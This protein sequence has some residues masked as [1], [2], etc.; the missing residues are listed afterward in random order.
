MTTTSATARSLLIVSLAFGLLVCCPVRSAD[1]G[2]LAHYAFDGDA[3]DSSVNGNNASASG[4]VD[5]TASGGG[6]TGN[7]GDRAVNFDAA[8]E[9]VVA[10]V[11]A[12]QTMN[13]NNAATVSLWVFGD[14]AQQPRNDTIFSFNQNGNRQFMS[15]LPWGDGTVYFDTGGCCGSNTR[16]TV[17][18]PAG[19]WKGA[20]NHYTYIKD[21]NNKSL[22]INGTIR[23]NQVGGATAPINA[24]NEAAIGAERTNGTNNYR[25]LV[26]DLGIWDVGLSPAEARALY[27]LAVEP[28]LQ[29]GVSDANR[30]FELFAAGTGDEA[31][32][33]LT[34]INASGLDGSAGDVLYLGG[35]AYQLVLDDNGNGLVGTVPEPAT[36]ALLGLA[37]TG[38][39][40][41]LRRRRT[42]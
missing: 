40:G 18:R 2:L 15:H 1:A 37:A 39:G 33:D 26:D 22:W 12:F 29:Y 21:G 7:V 27:T 23:I 24:F 41:Y 35:G 38:L 10:P 31:F 3:S 32:G 14:A 25:G 5:F 4:G 20:W 30:L 16:Q 6:F 28:G 8:G 34:W 13:T 11:A 17:N 19:E 9:V 36:L 42:A